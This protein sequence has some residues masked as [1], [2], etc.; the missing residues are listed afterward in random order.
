MNE[1]YIS[2]DIEIINFTEK[3]IISVSQGTE[4]LIIDAENP[5]L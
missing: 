1:P 2:I 3:D 5:S 4:G